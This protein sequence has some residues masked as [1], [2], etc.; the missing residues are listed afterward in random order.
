[1]A[2]GCQK[3]GWTF[4]VLTLSQG[5]SGGLHGQDKRPWEGLIWVE[6][7]LVL[8]NIFATTMDELDFPGRP[9]GLTTQV[10]I[11]KVT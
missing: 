6:R 8:K 4:Q 7:G 5:L 1:M 9:Q 11:N 10:K 2:L 3:S